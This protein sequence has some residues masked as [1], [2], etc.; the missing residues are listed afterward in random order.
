MATI[1]C[2]TTFLVVM[3]GRNVANLAPLLQA[4]HHNDHVLLVPTAVAGEESLAAFKAFLR[5]RLPNVTV[6]CLPALG[7]HSDAVSRWCEFPQVL[8]ALRLCDPK[9][10]ESGPYASGGSA[11]KAPVLIGNGGTKPLQDALRNGLN[12][13]MREVGAPEIH[14]LY[15]EARPVRLITIKDG[16]RLAIEQFRPIGGVAPDGVNRFLLDDVLSVAGFSRQ[17]GTPLWLPHDGVHAN[18]PAA[19]ARDFEGL[20]NSALT[21]DAG[22]ARQWVNLLRDAAAAEVAGLLQSDLALA[23]IVAELWC[24]PQ[25]IVCGKTMGAWDV[26]LVLRNGVLVHLDCRDWCPGAGRDDMH[27]ALRGLVDTTAWCVPLP[28]LTGPPAC[29]P[30]TVGEACHANYLQHPHWGRKRLPWTL[31]ET[32][33]NVGS[34]RLG[35]GDFAGGLNELLRPYV[36]GDCEP[37]V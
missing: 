13:M 7:S 31:G 33:V 30:T 25:A 34:D 8:A 32:K 28:A 35:Q 19:A 24:G 14:T 17:S 10:G 12:L 6:D 20:C 11:M 21:A 23:D 2:M 27:E 18:Q 3:T 36:P 9:P 15:A 22:L 5:D 4:C 37:D 16:S 29:P 26:L 1:W